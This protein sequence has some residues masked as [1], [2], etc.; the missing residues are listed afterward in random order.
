MTVIIFLAIA[1]LAVAIGFLGAF[2]WATKDG[3]Y[4]DTYT[5]SVRMLFDSVEKKSE[6]KIE[7]EKGV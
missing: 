1:A 2:I 4:D 6:P 3:Q 7:A 5:P